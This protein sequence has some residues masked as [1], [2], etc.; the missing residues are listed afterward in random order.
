M[1]IIY[2]SIIFNILILSYIKKLESEKCECSNQEKIKFIS[3][4][5]I[6]INL[7]LLLFFILNTPVMIK[8]I[9]IIVLFSCYIYQLYT[10]LNFLNNLKKPNSGCPCSKNWLRELIYYVTIFNVIFI[11][12]F[13]I[14]MLYSGIR[15]S[16]MSK[17]EKIEINN[18]SLLQESSKSN[19]IINRDIKKIF[20]K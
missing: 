9:S 17:E 20:G 18:A 3:Y 15:Y 6:I 2:L 7:I 10:L 14:K 11:S 8:N 5:I 16:V 1:I 19:V 4:G 12:V 13:S